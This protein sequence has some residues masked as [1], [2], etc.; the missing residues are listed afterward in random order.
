MSSLFILV[1]EKLFTLCKN[2]AK[3][4]SVYNFSFKSLEQIQEDDFSYPY[5]RDKE[6]GFQR[7]KVIYTGRSFLLP[8]AVRI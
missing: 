1:N 6:I 7:G 2:Y 4:P 3:K 5:F 8:E